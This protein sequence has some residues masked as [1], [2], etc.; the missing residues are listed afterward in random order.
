MEPVTIALVCIAGAL[1]LMLLGI[2][3]VYCLGCTGAVMAFLIYGPVSLDKAGWT[4]FTTL[5]NINWV[6][7]PLFVL[8][9]CII[10]QT[11]MGQDI[12]RAAR[13]WLSRLPGGLVVA[14]IFGEAAMASAV[15]S[16]TA[17]ALAVGKMAEPEFERYG[18]SKP[19]AMGALTCGGVLGPLI[20]PSI[21]FITY[22]VLAQV[23]IGQLFIA[24]IV[25]GIILAFMLAGVAVI[26]CW[27]N[28]VLGPPAG[29]VSWAERLSSLKKVWPLVAV[30]LSIIGTI[31]LGIA[32]A[33]EAAGVG[34]VV[35]IILAFFVYRLRWA[36]FYRAIVEAATLN[37][38]IL[39]MMV[40][41]WFYSYVLG[42]SGAAKSLME[43]VYG[44]GLPPLGIVFLI[45][46][47]LLIL[48]CFIDAI[49][50]M[51]LTIPLFVPI[52][53]GLGFDPVWFGV[54][55]VVNMQIGLITPPMGLD[56]FTVR[57]AFN[58]PAGHLLR[59]VLPFLVVLIIFLLLL[60]FFPQLSLWLPGTMGMGR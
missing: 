34:C 41:A 2:P 17:C 52:V 1:A 54:L 26:M 9:G 37:G 23:S 21:G 7:L 4:T 55:Y 36:D 13:N 58:L 46:I 10:S 32:S 6:P 49:T 30:M 22:G 8:M 25:P 15:G 38:M 28:P 19:F 50:I 31:Y 33:A 27:R 11:S 20:P 35:V 40:G 57:S 60:V 16:S 39:F 53:V 12:Y 5:Y 14:T 18:Y 29:A 51:L 48:G 47:I 43:L 3:V 45:N 42:T 24:G 44:T 56:L 59:G